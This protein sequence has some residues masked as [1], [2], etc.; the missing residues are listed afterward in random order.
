ME[1]LQAFAK[2]AFAKAALLA[3]LSKTAL[4][5]TNGAL[6][7]VNSALQPLA[8]FSRYLYDRE[9]H[10]TG[11]CWS[12]I[13]LYVSFGFCWRVGNSSPL[14]TTSVLPL[15]C[16]AMLESRLWSHYQRG[17]RTISMPFQSSQLSWRT[18]LKDAVRALRPQPWKLQLSLWGQSLS[19]RSFRRC[20]GSGLLHAC[21]VSGPR[22]TG[23]Q[24][25]FLESFLIPEWFFH[26]I[27]VN[28]VGPLPPSHGFTYLL[29]MMDMST[30]LPEVVSL[31]SATLV[32]VA[33]VFTSTWV[34]HFQQTLLLTGVCSSLPS[35][36]QLWTAVAA[37]LGVKLH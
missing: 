17:S 8:F 30:R 34:A 35:C 5:L 29:T 20:S 36:G 28:L 1:R 16:S 33:Q 22:C 23:T 19:G 14:W 32:K 6:G 21:S 13:W 12:S 31:S 7:W 24:S 25:H 3:H 11:S 2:A 4:A 18:D 10:L 37:N 9:R 27:H 26:H 15:L